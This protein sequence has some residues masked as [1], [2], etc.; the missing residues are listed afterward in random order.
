MAFPLSF[1]KRCRMQMVKRI[2]F[3][4]GESEFQA[5]PHPRSRIETQSAPSARK[6]LRRPLPHRAPRCQPWRSL[7]LRHP[8]SKSSLSLAFM[9]VSSYGCDPALASCAVLALLSRFPGVGRNS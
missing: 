9:P 1:V 5:C 2:C 6:G 7:L 8:C 3:K 4:G